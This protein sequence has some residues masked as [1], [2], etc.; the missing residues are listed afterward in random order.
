VLAQAEARIERAAIARA[1]AEIAR[2]EAKRALRDTVARAPFAGR[3]ADVTAVPGRLVSENEQLGLLIDPAALEVSFRLSN[4]EF[5]RL[6]DADGAVRPLPVTASLDVDG[7]P[8]EVPGELDRSSAATGEGRTGRLVYA[9]LAPERPGLLRPGDFLTVRI[10]EPKLT[11]V[12]VVPATAVSAEAR[13]WLVGADDRIEGAEVDVLRRDGD[14]VILGGVP[15]GRTFVTE[16]LPRIGPGVRVRPVSPG[17]DA[18]AAAAADADGTMVRLSPERRAGLI[19]AVEANRR[20]GDADRARLLAALAA[21]EVP[22]AM[23]DRLEARRSG[24]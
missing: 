4:A 3:L 22:Q 8:L 16:R 10:E 21:E 7:I 23:V 24:G 5:A 1:R 13:I 17:P 14:R 2:D 18:A 19:A 6:T 20:L 12:A 9:R 11:D 15:F